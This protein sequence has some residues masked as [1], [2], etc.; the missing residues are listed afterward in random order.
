M[1]LIISATG[2]DLPPHMIRSLSQRLDLAVDR[3]E[4][5]L[6]KITVHLER[7][8][9]SMASQSA[10]RADTFHLACRIHLTIENNDPIILDDRDDNLYELLDRVTERLGV[11][12]SKRA[13]NQKL[14]TLSRKTRDPR[15]ARLSNNWDY[16]N[17]TW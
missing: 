8:Q 14:R 7:K 2:L 4:T 17:S 13:D 1:E 6:Q 11:I 12:V 16:I 9:E 5:V 15:H 10:Q 3:L